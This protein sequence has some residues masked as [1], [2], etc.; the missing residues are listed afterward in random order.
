[1]AERKK[2]LI[3]DD[4]MILRQMYAERLKGED[5]EVLMAGDGQEAIEMAAKDK[6]DVILLDIMMPKMNGIDALKK[7]RA[8]ADTKSIPVVVLTALLQQ[9][10]QIKGL[11][12]PKDSHL[13]KSETMP[14]AVVEKIKAAVV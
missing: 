14:G 12:G 7:L 9:I 8:E 10:D 11:L 2:V 4:D 5:F 1:M 3:V 6:P 13:I